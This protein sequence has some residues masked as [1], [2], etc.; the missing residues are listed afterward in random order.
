MCLD[1]SE[2]IVAPLLRWASFPSRPP[3]LT[4]CFSLPVSSEGTVEV[5]VADVRSHSC[6]DFCLPLPL[7][8]EIWQNSR[9]GGLAWP[10][11]RAPI[12]DQVVS[13]SLSSC[14]I[15]CRKWNSVYSTVL[16]MTDI[17]QHQGRFHSSAPCSPGCCGSAARLTQSHSDGSDTRGVGGGGG[18]QQH[19]VKQATDVPQQPNQL[20]RA[21]GQISKPFHPV[22]GTNSAWVIFLQGSL[23]RV[24]ALLFVVAFLSRVSLRHATS[25]WAAARPLCMRMRTAC[26][27]CITQRLCRWGRLGGN[28][29]LSFSASQ[30]P[31]GEAFFSGV[32]T[33]CLSVTVHVKQAEPGS[34]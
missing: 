15:F 12:W 2:E 33:A 32:L 4:L 29:H 13:H 19:L 1:S 26:A 8:I 3:P 10:P 24:G 17:T 9:S 6:I 18:V 30:L 20:L 14:Y 5:L 7:A 16:H 25:G 31:Y 28:N 27:Q 21:P 23:H 22:P 11:L 34:P